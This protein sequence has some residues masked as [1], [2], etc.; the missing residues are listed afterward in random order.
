MAGLL[1]YKEVS[2][3]CL[4]EELAISLLSTSLRPVTRLAVAELPFWQRAEA[5]T[6]HALN[7][8]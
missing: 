3:A 6:G 7:H 4:A 8:Q 5:Y 2:A 1:S